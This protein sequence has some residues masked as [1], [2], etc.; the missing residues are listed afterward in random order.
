ME[1][2]ICILKYFIFA[3]YFKIKTIF[4]KTKSAHFVDLMGVRLFWNNVFIN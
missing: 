1:I 2:K 4:L 3:K